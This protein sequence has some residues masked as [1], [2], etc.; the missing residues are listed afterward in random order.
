M[1][2]EFNDSAAP[3]VV[4]LF[5]SQGCSS[6][7]PADEL[8]ARI[9][10]WSNG[11]G[12]P[13]YCLSFH[14]DYWNRLGWN[15]PYSSQQ[16][17]ARQRAYARAFESDRV[18]TPQMIVNGEEEFVGSQGGDATEALKRALKREPKYTIE[19]QARP[20]DD[21]SAL[22]QYRITGNE[23]GRVLNIALVQKGVENDVPRGEN[24]GRALAHVNVV[25]SLKTVLLDEPSGEVVI[26]L[27][28]ELKYADVH[29]VAYVQHRHTLQ[30]H[31][32]STAQIK[33][34]F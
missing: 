31:G 22:I 4:E 20:S 32:A 5:T 3:T 10:E 19:L 2:E 21:G 29:V 1:S 7:P 27:P 26:N 9:D 15:D 12:V 28:K 33:D 18:Y 8:L 23:P 34:V 24:A 11:S 25:R 6:C 13:V 30:I 14:V 16:F 17:S